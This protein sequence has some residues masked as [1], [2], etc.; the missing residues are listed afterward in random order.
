MRFVFFL[1]LCV[2]YSERV[3]VTPVLRRVPLPNLVLLLI[4][5]ELLPFNNLV[6]FV[7]VQVVVFVKIPRKPSQ[8]CVPL[9]NQRTNPLK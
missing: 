8:L 2:P 7:G 1:L 9:V 4:V 3:V 5:G 6:H